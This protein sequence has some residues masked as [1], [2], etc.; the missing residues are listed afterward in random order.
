MDSLDWSKLV[1][2]TGMLGE[3]GIQQ[4]ANMSCEEG[5]EEIKLKK[6]FM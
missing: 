4:Q 1:F 3:L 5:M 6:N 2:G